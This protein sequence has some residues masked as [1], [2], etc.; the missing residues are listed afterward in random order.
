LLAVVGGLSCYATETVQMRDV[1]ALGGSLTDKRVLPE[2]SGK[3]SVPLD[4]MAMVRA[5]LADGGYTGWRRA[6]KLFVSNDAL[7]FEEGVPDDRI[8]GAT[9]SDIGPEDATLLIELAP[10][11]GKVTPG[12]GVAPDRYRLTAPERR[13]IAAWANRFVVLQ[14]QK[15]RPAGTWQFHTPKNVLPFVGATG[16]STFIVPVDELSRPLSDE[17]RIVFAV[18]APWSKLASFEVNY[19]DVYHF[20]LA[21]PV[22]PLLF[23]LTPEDRVTEELLDIDLEPKVIWRSSQG[24]REPLFTLNGQRR[25]IVKMLASS[26][27]GSTWRGDAFASASFGLRFRGFYDFGL[28]ARE[29][30]LASN[31]TQSDRRQSFFWGVFTGLHVAIQGDPRFAFYL[32]VEFTTTTHANRIGSG[33]FVFGPRFSFKNGLFLAVTPLGLGKIDEAFRIFSSAQLGLA[34]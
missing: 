26:E 30:S 32:G 7:Y 19:F 28:L 11:G 21:L 24:P 13:Q 9:V 33:A 4:A 15:D 25:A 1:R 20:A 17:K 12:G 2:A 34:F 16:E 22:F 6:S 5:Q 3:G 29:M 8:T 10:A 14:K 27:L 31:T 18:G 23:L